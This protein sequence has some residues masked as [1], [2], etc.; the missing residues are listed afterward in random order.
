M[1]TATLAIDDWDYSK[2]S[3]GG[4]IADRQC[5]IGDSIVDPP[6]QSPIAT[7]QIGNRQS[8]VGNV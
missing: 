3:I 1:S 6:C 7:A 5:Q 4:A 2:M 8:A